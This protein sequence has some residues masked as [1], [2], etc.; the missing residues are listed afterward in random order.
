M[1]FANIDSNNSP[2]LSLKEGKHGHQAVNQTSVAK[3]SSWIA[4]VC[5][6]PDRFFI[7]TLNMNNGHFVL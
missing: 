1:E 3:V 7:A 6:V 5:P 2:G 4:G